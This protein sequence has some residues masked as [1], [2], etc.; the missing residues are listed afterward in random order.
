MDIQEIIELFNDGDLDI[1]TYFNDS[2][3]FFKIM[4]KR[5][6][7]DELDLEDQYKSMVALAG[8]ML[9]SFFIIALILFNFIY[10]IL[11]TKILFLFLFGEIVFNYFGLDGKRY[12][13]FKQ[14]INNN[15]YG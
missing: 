13:K 8:P 5:G 10:K 2:E 12:K 1:K 4:T 3:T 6:V 14:N 7:I 15:C 11:S 9:A